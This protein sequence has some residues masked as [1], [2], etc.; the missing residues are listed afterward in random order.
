M[1]TKLTIYEVMK[2]VL[3]NFKELISCRFSDHNAIVIEIQK[4]NS[5][6]TINLELEIIGHDNKIRCHFIPTHLIKF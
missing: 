2:Q 1:F 6:K 3:I 4:Q 5:L